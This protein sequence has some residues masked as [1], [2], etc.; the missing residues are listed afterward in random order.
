MYIPSN[1]SF[2]LS[3]LVIAPD[4]SVLYLYIAI[5]LIT[6]KWK[7]DQDKEQSK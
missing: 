2:G 1:Q 5:Q 7:A 6:P 4:D 3:P